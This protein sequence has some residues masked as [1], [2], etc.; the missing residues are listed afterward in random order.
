M[1]ILLIFFITYMGALNTIN[2]EVLS[3]KDAS[4]N[5]IFT[6]NRL[7]CDITKDDSDR[8]NGIVIVNT[9]PRCGKK[10]TNKH[11]VNYCTPSREYYRAGKGWAIYL[12]K[13]LVDDNKLYADKALKKLEKSL[14]EILEKLPDTAA[15]QL[16]SLDIYLMK[17]E[18]FGVDEGGMSY[19][20]PGEAKK[21]II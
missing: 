6:D 19:K 16:K 1:K 9:S 18:K 7:D 17:G 13:T 5:V 21:I 14:D 3:C 12:E 4:G 20:R 10:S 2:A 11:K 8:E 15:R